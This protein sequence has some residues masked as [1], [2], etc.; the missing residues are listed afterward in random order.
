MPSQVQ[1][2]R[3]EL[4]FEVTEHLALEIKRYLGATLRKDTHSLRFGDSGYPVCSVY[5]DSPD[6]LLLKQTLDGKRNRYKLRVRIYDDERSQPAFAEIKRRDGQVIKKQRAS[7][8]RET[9]V[10]LLSGESVAYLPA[11]DASRANSAGL[12]KEWS[13]L[14]EFCRLRDVIGGVGRTYVS[15][16]RDAYVSPDGVQWRA[17]FDRHLSAHPYRPGER[18]AIPT[19][20]I[21]VV[22]DSL[23][24]FELKFTNRF[25]SWMQELVRVFDL[26]AVSFPKYVNCE[27]SLGNEVSLV[28]SRGLH[29]FASSAQ[30]AG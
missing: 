18:I 23:V 3:R 19:D 27:R 10:A 2:T 26:G 15:Y 9:A 4:K 8:S 7:V 5:L 24:V 17:T 13:A 21:D 12:S 30:R 11:A 20:G 1:P 22:D 16:L 29:P 6:S 28:T 14:H 25:P